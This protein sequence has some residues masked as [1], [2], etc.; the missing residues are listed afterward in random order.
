MGLLK[1]G[2]PE[3]G[4]VAYSCDKMPTEDD[5]ILAMLGIVSLANLFGGRDHA[6][7][8]SEIVDVGASQGF[9]MVCRV[10]AH[11]GRGSAQGYPR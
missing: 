5:H 6:F 3:H 2:L 10:H 8:A 1:S 11:R 7:A 4:V 9:A